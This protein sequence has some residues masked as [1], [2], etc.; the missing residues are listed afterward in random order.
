MHLSP[1]PRRSI[2]T[3]F[4]M[5]ITIPIHWELPDMRRLP[6]FTMRIPAPFVAFKVSAGSLPEYPVASTT[7]ILGL[8]WVPSVPGGG[9]LIWVPA[10]YVRVARGMRE[11]VRID[12]ATG[13]LGG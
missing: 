10:L 4:R 11:S 8:A 12:S 3:L 5:T 1:P 7:T 6:F 9:L 13:A 2:S